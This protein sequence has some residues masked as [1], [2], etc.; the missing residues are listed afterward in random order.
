MIENDW[1]NPEINKFNW[2]K[3]MIDLV[4]RAYPNE[5]DYPNLKKLRVEISRLYDQVG[6]IQGQQFYYYVDMLGL[7]RRKGHQSI[8][9]RK[10]YTKA[11][12]YLITLR[13]LLEVGTK[14]FCP[15]SLQ[16]GLVLDRKL[17]WTGSFEY[18]IRF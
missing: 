15:D 16:K 6:E 11:G 2:T 4:E 10:R 5:Q 8:L 18:K 14:W 17:L 7:A 3:P 12:Q 9:D 13:E 1:N